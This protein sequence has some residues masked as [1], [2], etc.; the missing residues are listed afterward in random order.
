MVLGIQWLKGL[1]V[2]KWDFANLVIEFEYDS[3]LH[4][5]HGLLP[6][7][8]RNLTQ[9]ISP[10]LVHSTSQMFML[11]LLPPTSKKVHKEEVTLLALTADE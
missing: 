2:E 3:T 5:L 7:K 6:Q 4:V 10:K 11:Q 1:G 9:H 8:I